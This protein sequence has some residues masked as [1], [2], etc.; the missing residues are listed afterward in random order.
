M[1]G[2]KTRSAMSR[3]KAAFDWF[4][5]RGMCHREW[6]CAGSVQGGTVPRL[7]PR[8]AVVLRCYTITLVYPADAIAPEPLRLLHRT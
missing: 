1:P 6:D 2:L 7:G 5:S 8:G 4:G 3:R